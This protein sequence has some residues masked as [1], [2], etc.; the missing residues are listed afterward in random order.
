MLLRRCNDVVDGGTGVN[1]AAYGTA[2]SAVTVTLLTPWVQ[3]NTLGAGLDTLTSI[4]NL[5][6]SGFGDTLTGDAGNNVLSGLAG[7]DTLFGDN[8]DDQLAGGDG[9][10]VLDGGTGVNTAV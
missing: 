9:N 10:D 6:G 3:Q 2:S 4:Q 7:N 5:T 1:T 8:G